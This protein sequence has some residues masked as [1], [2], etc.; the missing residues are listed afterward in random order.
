MLLLGIKMIQLYLFKFCLAVYIM[1]G[2]FM[3][4]TTFSTYACFE[5]IIMW[6]YQYGPAINLPTCTFPLGLGI[7][8]MELRQ[9]VLFTFS[10]SMSIIWAVYRNESWAWV[11]QDI[12]G[13]LFRQESSLVLFIFDQSSQPP[14]PK[15]YQRE[16]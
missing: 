1:I 8:K 11:L 3:F 15:P 9:L 10:V 12:L 4:A 7:L 13:I 2:M 14:S 6:S 5:P 16:G